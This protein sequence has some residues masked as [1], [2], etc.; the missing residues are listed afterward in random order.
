MA[1]SII[2]YP[3]LD[4]K[5][6]IETVM[7]QIGIKVNV[8]SYKADVNNEI[9]GV[10]MGCTSEYQEPTPMQ[11][12]QFVD[13]TANVGLFTKTDALLLAEAAEE[14]KKI[15]FAEAPYKDLVSFKVNRMWVSQ[16]TIDFSETDSDGNVQATIVF[17]IQ[18][19]K[20]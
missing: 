19:L 7:K 2:K 12:H 13:I 3:T 16:D 4:V 14:L 10:V 20:I 8:D 6:G 18:Y 9:Q 1:N 15:N 11:R 5:K 17:N